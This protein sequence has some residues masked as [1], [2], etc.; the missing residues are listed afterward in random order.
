[1]RSWGLMALLVMLGCWG[2]SSMAVDNKTLLDAPENGYASGQY[3]DVRSGK[4]ADY[5]FFA[6]GAG[7]AAAG[8]ASSLLNA[9]TTSLL[10]GS[11]NPT[12]SGGGG[13]MIGLR[14]YPAPTQGDPLPFARG[15]AMINYSKKLKRISYDQAGGVIEYEFDSNPFAAQTS[16]YQPP[17]S[18]SRLPSSFGY[19][20]VE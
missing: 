18:K 6:T 5:G 9:G 7:A 13:G 15:V 19:Q 2:C 3:R 12:S 10:Q 20:P 11:S 8:G 14:V 1:M 4:V 17:A 16:A